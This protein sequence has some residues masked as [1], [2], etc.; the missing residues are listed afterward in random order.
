[1][2]E[3]DDAPIQN[4]TKALTGRQLCVLNTVV[5]N[6]VLIKAVKRALKEAPLCVLHMEEAY[7]ALI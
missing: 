1:M 2:V 3:E 6:D 7:D 4:A 5:G